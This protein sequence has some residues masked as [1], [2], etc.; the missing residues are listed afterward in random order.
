MKKFNL[1]LLASIISSFSLNATASLTHDEILTYSNTD[2]NQAQPGWSDTLTI[3]NE[4]DKPLVIK[5][6]QF[7]TNYK[8]L[9]TGQLYGS[10]LHSATPAVPQKI[11]DFIYRYS[12]TTESP[13]SKGVYTTI[14]AKS[15]VTLTQIPIAHEQAEENGIPVFY[16]VPFNVKVTLSDD[17]EIN[18]SLR[19][20]CQENA[21]NDPAPGKIIGAY[22][23]NWANYHYSQNPQN[24]LFPNQIPIKNMNTIFYAIGKVNNKTGTI[25]FVDIN[26]D[27][28]YLPAFDILRQQYPYLNV[29]YS[30]GGWGDDK[31]NSYPSYDLA[32]IFDQQNPELI[33]TL[34][35]NLV[36]AM[37]N[38]G[39]NGIDID[40]EWNAIQPGTSELMQLTNARALGYQQLLQAIRANLD[41]IQPSHDKHYYKVTSAVFAGP[42]KIAEFE[43]NGGDWSKVADALDY[44]N[45]M[46]Y[47]LHGQFDVAQLS[48]DNITD[49]H[50]AMQTEH[51]YQYDT[52]NHY[53]A[54]DAVASYQAHGVAANK[55]VIGIP[56]YTR[57]EKTAVSVTDENKGL[58]L[59]LA[60]DQ[61]LGESGSGGTT[62]YKCIVDSRYCWN[63]FDFNRNTLVYM[64]AILSA[65]STALGALA[66]TPWAYD[67]SQNWFMSFDDGYSAKYKAQWA[68][69]NNL[70]GV[71]MWE[72]D[73]DVPVTDAQFEE[74]SIL[75]N[76]WIGLTK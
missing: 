68:K 44:L 20:K 8:S 31:S 46:T 12:M 58:Y 38:M 60:N 76:V 16:R 45:V 30:V 26:H 57:I 71:M 65:E 28:Y 14:P 10:I 63:G 5:Q 15:S 21:C 36:N 56:A 24:M 72:A 62:D 67:K 23:T 2:F 34:A 17:T 75:Y 53:N 66:R 3:Y 52:L 51:S 70:G 39:L 73:G 11:N 33:Q 49:F 6:L 13:Y 59:M 9:D 25:T 50:S 37:L 42:D 48:P 1:T 4:T 22:F 32:A 35:K 40:Y 27:Q 55:I 43:N 74:K 64:P 18:V 7:D 29:L 54:T 69:Q 47:D 19:D 41:K 61:P